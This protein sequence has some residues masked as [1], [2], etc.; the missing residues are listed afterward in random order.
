MPL[1]LN[2][3]AGV[4]PDGSLPELAR[5]ITAAFLKR[6][7]LSGNAVMTPNVTMQVQSLPPGSTFSGGTPV[8]GAWLECKVPS[9]ALADRAVQEGFLADATALIAEAAGGALPRERIWAN[10]VHT[11]DG[12]WNLDGRAMTNAE[13]GAAISEG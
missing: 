10:A 1:A 7:G 13:L 2:Y 11:V 4:L 5:A 12:T 9:F 8:S 3:T 6:H